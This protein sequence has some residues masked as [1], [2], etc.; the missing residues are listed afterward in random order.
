MLSTILDV[1]SIQ[2]KTISAGIRLIIRVLAA[3]AAWV[4]RMAL[5]TN[6]AVAIDEWIANACACA[7]RDVQSCS[8]GTL[9]STLACSLLRVRRYTQKD[10]ALVIL[11]AVQFA[12]PSPH[13]KENALSGIESLQFE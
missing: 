9:A 1:V 5:G 6:F 2:N 8:F 7:V 10:A 4:R 11:Y 3:G 12:A 13:G